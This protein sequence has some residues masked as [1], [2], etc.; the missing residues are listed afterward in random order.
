MK[1]TPEKSFGF[2][3]EYDGKHYAAHLVAAN[4]DEAVA[5]IRSLANGHC[6]GQLHSDSNATIRQVIELANI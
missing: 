2:E 1:N 4:Q 5:R 6:I 3:Y